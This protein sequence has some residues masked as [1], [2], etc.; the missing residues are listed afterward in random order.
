MFPPSSSFSSHILLA[1]YFFSSTIS[2]TL[3]RLLLLRTRKVLSG[4][5]LNYLKILTQHFLYIIFFSSIQ[6]S[7][8]LSIHPI[9]YHHH[10]LHLL[11]RSHFL[12]LYFEFIQQHFSYYVKSNGLEFNEFRKN[13]SN[14]KMFLFVV[15]AFTKWRASFYNPIIR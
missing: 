9:L 6:P 5:L 3:F 2:Y 4:Y 7:I 15:F 1:V 12:F 10:H 8:Y 14:K 11:I 13:G